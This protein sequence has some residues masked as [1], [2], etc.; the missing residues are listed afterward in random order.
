[1]T[2]HSPTKIES[3]TI[4]DL[5]QVYAPRER[6]LIVK[7]LPSETESSGGIALPEVVVMP[8]ETFTVLGAGPRAGCAVGDVVAFGD[9]NHVDLWDP[10]G[11]FVDSDNV[12]V[13]QPF[14]ASHGI[15]WPWTPM[16]DNVLIVPNK[17]IHR[18]GEGQGQVGHKTESGIIIASHTLHGFGARSMARGE[19][20]Y[21][22][23]SAVVLS[24]QY[25]AEPSEFYRHRHIHRYLD[26]L[27]AWEIEAL[28]EYLD[29]TS[30]GKE[31][32]WQGLL[33]GRRRYF[34]ESGFVV[35]T[36]PDCKCGLEAGDTVY[37]DRD[38]SYLYLDCSSD[39]ESEVSA[40]IVVKESQLAAF[41]RPETED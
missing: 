7:R 12:D 36:G 18:G 3:T 25:A 6:M 37:F 17:M 39:P 38:F 4:D 2:T 41:T 29:R 13:V 16:R 23:L 33:R 20:I 10:E 27:S 15:W 35:E 26:R 30:R 31:N 19:D 8:V 11:G 5:A 24:P 32:N 14:D 9:R 22:E 1:M 28:H 34:Y 21:R 40:M